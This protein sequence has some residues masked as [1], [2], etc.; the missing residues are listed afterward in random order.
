LEVDSKIWDDFRAGKE[1]ALSHVYYQHVDLLHRYGKKFSHDNDL[2]KDTI[3]DLFFDL[4]RT[5]KN[6]GATDNIRF[7]LMCSFR[8]K[9]IQNLKKNKQSD[10]FPQS[11]PEP[12]IIYSIE[13]ELIGR[14][15]LSKR[16]RIIQNCLQELNPRQREILYYRY[17][18]NLKYDDICEL[19]SLKY[20]SAR[21][22]VHRAIES[23]KKMLCTRDILNLFYGIFPR[24]Q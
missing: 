18:C 1:Y 4:I 8:R 9:L 24:I 13:E 10:N 3:Q 17:T 23:L 16:D 2:V 20:D 5:R 21:K 19:M 11:N 7:Y 12:S 15:S 14:E 22:L 6:L